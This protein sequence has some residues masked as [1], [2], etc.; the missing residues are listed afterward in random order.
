M[1][2]IA[3]NKHVISV[4]GAHAKYTSMRSG[5]IVLSNN[6]FDLYNTEFIIDNIETVVLH[7]TYWHIK[8]SEMKRIITYNYDS[9]T[10]FGART[11]FNNKLGWTRLSM[12][13]NDLHKTIFT[14]RAIE[15]IVL[16]S[17][18]SYLERT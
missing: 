17:T 3:F 12:F 18:Y 16:H 6:C 10:V 4:A 7:S 8:R 1:K 15:T 2:I 14:P 13:N 5:Y 9:I 11:V